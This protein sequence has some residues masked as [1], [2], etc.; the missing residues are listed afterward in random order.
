MI[1]LDEDNNV[2]EEVKALGILLHA[3][4]IIYVSAIIKLKICINNTPPMALVDSGSTH[5]FIQEKV[6]SKLG[7]LVTPHEVLSVK[8]TN[9][10]R[11]ASKGVALR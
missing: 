7:L 1:E 6:S 11:I 9:D 2:E 5:T 4:T 3:L 8:F 10:A